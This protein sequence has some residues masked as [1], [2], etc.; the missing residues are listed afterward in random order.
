VSL[1]P[2]YCAFGVPELFFVFVGSPVHSSFIATFDNDD[3]PFVS[4]M[5][6]ATLKRRPPCTHGQCAHTLGTKNRENDNLQETTLDF[7]AQFCPFV[8]FGL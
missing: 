6:G 8:A 5:K 4:K 2:L 7:V 3:G 1:F